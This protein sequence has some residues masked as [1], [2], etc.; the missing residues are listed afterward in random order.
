MSI[1]SAYTD[2]IKIGP[3]VTNP[4]LV[5][6]VVTA[7]AICSLNEVAPGRVI[8]GLGVGDKTTLAMVDVEQARP[9]TYI[10]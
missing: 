2:R 4:Y 7:Q 3:G 5:H 6:P 9:L 10:R 1:I 8:C